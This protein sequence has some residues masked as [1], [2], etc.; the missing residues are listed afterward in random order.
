MYTRV[1]YSNR[2]AM[3]GVKWQY[4]AD[5]KSCVLCE[6]KFPMYT[7]RND[8]SKHHCRMC[9]RVLCFSCTS[10][11]LFYEASGKRQRTCNECIANGGPPEHCKANAADQTTATKA[12][13]QV[14]AQE[15]KEAVKGA[16]DD[17]LG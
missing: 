5:V 13:F 3:F 17:A 8:R 9:G 4:K 16:V 6:Y 2:E 12:V 1:K 14:V 10:T 11:M 7:V 15:A